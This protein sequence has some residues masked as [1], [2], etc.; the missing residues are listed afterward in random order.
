[1][2]DEKVKDNLCECLAKVKKVQLLMIICVFIILP[3]A[4]ILDA[5]LE[6]FFK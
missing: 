5:V 3:A 2:N 6:I 4:F 1:M